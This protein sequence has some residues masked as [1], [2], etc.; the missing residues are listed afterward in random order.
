MSSVSSMPFIQEKLL[1]GS[2]WR[3][4]DLHLHAPTSVFNNQF[5]GKGEKSAW[6]AYLDALERLPDTP[7]LGVT[8]YFSIEGYKRLREEK[9]KNGRLS[10]NALLLPN[11][12]FRLNLLIPTKLEKDEAKVKKVNAHVIF[13]DEV[14][15]QDIEQHFLLQLKFSA[16]GHPQGTNEQWTL[17]Q[18]QLEKFGERLKAEHAKFTDSAYEV[19]CMNAS[20]DF[21]S[22]KQ[23]LH[24]HRSIFENKYLIFVAS[25][26]LGLISWDGQGHQIRKSLIRGSDGFF[27]NSSD[28]EF[29][30]GKRHNTQDS[31][32]EEFGCLKPCIQGTD[33]HDLDAIGQPVDGNFCWIKSD[34]TFEGLRQVAFEPE[35]RIYLGD[36]PPELKHPYRVITSVEVQGAPDWFSYATLPLNPALVSVIGGKGAGKSALAEMISFAGG[37]EV[38][39][40]KRVKDLQDTFLA[41]ASKRTS[42]N[43]KPLTGAQIKLKWGDGHE[44]TVVITEA[45][46]HGLDDEKVKYLPQ[47]FVERVCSPENHQELLREMER[48]I[49]QRIPRTD[50]L[51]LSTFADLREQRTKGIAIKKTHL[52]DEI[53]ALNREVYAAFE[54]VSSRTTKAKSLTDLKKSLAS[55]IKDK[56]DVTTV[57]SSDLEKLKGLQAQ[58]QAL[59]SQLA[60]L[61]SSLSTLNEIE[62]KF[63]TM[64]SRL[65]SFNE[66]VRNLLATVGLLDHAESFVVQLPQDY[67][68]VL[69]A[70]RKQLSSETVVLRDGPREGSTLVTTQTEIQRTT[71]SLNFSQSRRAAF[72]KFETDRIAIEEQISSFEKE[73]KAIDATLVGELAAQRQLRVEKYLDYFEVLKEE[74]EALEALYAPLRT[75][76]ETDSAGVRKLEF[77]ARIAFD[78]QG[79]ATDGS[80]LFDSRRKGRFKDPELLQSELKKL[81]TELEAVQFDRD[82]AKRRILSF[83][84]SFLSDADGVAITIGDQLR[85]TKSEEDFNN[86]FFDL[87]PYTVEYSIT[88]EGRDLSLLSPGQKGIVLLMVYLEVDHEDQ[89]PLIIDQPED[90][91]DNLSVYSNLI[92]FFRKRKQ[93][94]QIIL[95]THNPNLVVNTDSEQIVIASYQGERNPKIVYKAG[96]IEDT[97]ITPTGIREDVCAILEGGTEAFQRRE[98]KYSLLS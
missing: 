18:Y 54:R 84:E 65:S 56:P 66:E 79:H 88:F 13:S 57:N 35:E 78:S 6:E 19:G 96:A 4:W 49:F 36:A 17:S 33:A 39:R 24:D 37:T 26:N 62:V 30:L 75:A 74:K 55:L 67:R 29:L 51:G 92:S 8:D 72:E 70:K 68:Q 47:K 10:N 76:L 82:T 1:I 93:Y 50:R 38:F 80:E 98:R 25:E 23:A 7:V 44:D 3:K 43:L 15:E 77:Q 60:T 20:V 85:K 46:D 97:A 34:P 32:I 90:N 28:R 2:I 41:K 9:K 42:T 27:G 45:L 53:A 64:G 94:R 12:E 52:S 73:I 22:I 58:L 31:F 61:Q 59:E 89:R 71:A 21:D 11:I 63:S 14:S 95:V 40:N 48:V 87:S 81:M 5:K 91:L 69:E 83:R 86:W 16:L